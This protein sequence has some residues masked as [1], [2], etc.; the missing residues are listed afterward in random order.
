MSGPR[1]VLAFLVAP[2]AVPLVSACT[3]PLVVHSGL[4]R[5]QP[6]ISVGDVLDVWLYFSIGH[7]VIA[8]LCE[9]AVGIV[10]WKIFRYFGIR[11]L[12]AFAAAGGVMGWLVTVPVIIRGLASV[13]NPYSWAPL[14]EGICCAT[15]FRLVVFS[16]DR[17]AADSK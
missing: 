4:I 11:S 9:L 8:Y 15:L 17:E 10:T 2:L 1:S 14:A 6:D 16:R 7:M 5:F 3:I 13:S 12:L